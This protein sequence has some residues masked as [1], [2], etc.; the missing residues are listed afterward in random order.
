MNETEVSSDERDGEDNAACFPA[1]STIELKNG[2]TIRMKGLSIFDDVRVSDDGFLAFSCSLIG[3][4]ISEV[5]L[6]MS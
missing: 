1:D 5:P 4:L 3:S 6:Y 2:S